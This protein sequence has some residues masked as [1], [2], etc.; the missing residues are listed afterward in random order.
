M[1]YIK[2]VN[3]KRVES[4][5]IVLTL[6]KSQ[7]VKN[8]EQLH[9]YTGGGRSEH[10]RITENVVKKEIGQRA[11]VMTLFTHDKFSKCHRIPSKSSMFELTE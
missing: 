2:E 4:V 5:E 10:I 3:L 1:L 11:G 6:Q 9:K 7:V 8:P